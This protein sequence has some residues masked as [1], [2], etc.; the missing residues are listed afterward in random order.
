MTCP[1]FL[2]IKDTCFSALLAYPLTGCDSTD[3]VSRA[4]Q[5]T[6]FPRSSLL[7]S[8]HPRSLVFYSEQTIQS[9]CCPCTS[10][11]TNDFNYHVHMTTSGASPAP[12]PE[13]YM[14]LQP[15]FLYNPHPPMLFPSISNLCSVTF[16][17][18]SHPQVS[19]PRMTSA[20]PQLTSPILTSFFRMALALLY[21][22]PSLL[23]PRSQA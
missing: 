7:I 17:L 9:P 8:W 16:F 4:V 10:Q 3:N 6:V 1:L 22:G 20:P 14:C 19:V 2:H 13:L 11:T 21:S 5:P 23:H 18:C 12:S 15:G